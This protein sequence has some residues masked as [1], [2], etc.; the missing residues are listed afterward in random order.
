MRGDGRTRGRKTQ[1]T[2]GRSRE[3]GGQGPNEWP[4][5]EIVTKKEYIEVK[6][7]NVK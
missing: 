3:V 2:K 6:E 1:R 5:A 7:R 4:E